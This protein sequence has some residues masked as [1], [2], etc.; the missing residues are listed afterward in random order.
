MPVGY[1]VSRQPRP[2]GLEQ[3]SEAEEADVEAMCAQARL[4]LCRS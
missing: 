1:S 4:S 2:Y 3:A